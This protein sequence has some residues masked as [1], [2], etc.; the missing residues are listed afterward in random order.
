[1][2]SIIKAKL[3]LFRGEKKKNCGEQINFSSANHD[4]FGWPEEGSIHC[5]LDEA[6]RLQSFAFGGIKYL[7]S[8]YAA[9]MHLSPI[10]AA[11]VPEPQISVLLKKSSL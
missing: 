7:P 5:A 11:C 4:G 10:V 2:Q 8:L 9:K 1:M 3:P 6:E